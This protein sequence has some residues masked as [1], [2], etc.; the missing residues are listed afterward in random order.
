[1]G[2]ALP[3]FNETAPAQRKLVSVRQISKIET[4]PGFG[5]IAIHVDGWKVL[6]PRYGSL[7]GCKV[8]PFCRLE[9][10]KPSAQLLPGF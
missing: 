1:M 6:V 2:D 8:C 7:K 4:N 10:A 3:D 9:D 5:K